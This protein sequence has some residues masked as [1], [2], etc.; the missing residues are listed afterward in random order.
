MAD[1]ELTMADLPQG[2]LTGTTDQLDEPVRTSV[3]FSRLLGSR[4]D[5]VGAGVDQDDGRDKAHGEDEVRS[6]QAD[7]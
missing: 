4:P 7:G 2:T 3:S 1:I 5:E 6:G